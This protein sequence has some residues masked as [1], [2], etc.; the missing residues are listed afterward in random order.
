MPVRPSF[1]EPRPTAELRAEHS[2]QHAPLPALAVGYRLPDPVAELDSYLAYVVLS[3]VLTDGDSAR[4]Q[5]RMV[6]KDALVNDV[7]TGT[8]LFGAPLDAR[9]PDTFTFTAVH[10]DDVSADRVLAVL[11]EEL[12]LI[13][14]DGPDAEELARVTARWTAGLH[15]DNDRIVS[16]TLA[17][18]GL[19]LLQGRPEL[20]GELPGLVARVTA[21][22]VSAAAKAMRPDSRAVLILTPANGAT[23]ESTPAGGAE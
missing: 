12:E 19:E 16:R 9:D 13:A 2:D 20:L 23:T 21:E 22:D 3:S 11:D 7:G 6:H 18:G 14:A 1:D 4:L 5:Q 8:G 15:R 10:T 17:Y